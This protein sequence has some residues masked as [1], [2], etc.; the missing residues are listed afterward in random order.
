[1]TVRRTSTGGGLTRLGKTL[2][3]LEE[4]GREIE[5]GIFGGR[6]HVSDRPGEQPTLAQLL[7]WHELG[8][9][10]IPARRPIR[11][12]IESKGPAEIAA[13]TKEVLPAVLRGEADVDDALAAIGGVAVAGVRKGI[14]ERLPP[15]LAPPTLANPKRDP[16]GI[17][18]FDTGQLY[19][20]IAVRIGGKVRRV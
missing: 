6:R 8:T 3:E 14:M 2:R 16:R 10:T 11:S 1:V 18:L 12:Y 7:A 17:P 13:R 20:A 5:V 4:K 9:K 15:P 19:R